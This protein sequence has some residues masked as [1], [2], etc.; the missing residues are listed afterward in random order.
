[1]NLGEGVPGMAQ[2]TT[3]A[4]VPHAFVAFPD[5]DVEEKDLDEVALRHA[6]VMSSGWDLVEEYIA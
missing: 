6:R 1:M 3:S 4:M 5:F 2:P